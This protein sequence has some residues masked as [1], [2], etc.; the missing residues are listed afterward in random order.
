MCRVTCKV[1]KEVL[2]IDDAQ[3]DNQIESAR[4]RTCKRLFKTGEK[5]NIFRNKNNLLTIYR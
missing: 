3:I 1:L 4:A 5:I 2:R